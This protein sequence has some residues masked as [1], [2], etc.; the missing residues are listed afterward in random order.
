MKKEVE[1]KLSEQAKIILTGLQKS[2]LKLTE[3]EIINHMNSKPFIIGTSLL[4]E[5]IA[6]IQLEKEEKGGG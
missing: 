3:E 2:G 5:N 6:E 4:M 1:I